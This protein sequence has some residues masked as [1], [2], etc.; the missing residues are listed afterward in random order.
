[1]DRPVRAVPSFGGSW[2]KINPPLS[3]WIMNVINKMGFTNMTPVQAATIPRAIKN[4]DCVVEAVTGSG[5]TLSFVVPVLERLSRNEESLQKDRIAAIVIAPTR[6]LATQIHSV[7]NQFLSSL[8]PSS[9]LEE[10]SQPFA[11]SSRAPSPESFDSLLPLPMLVTSGTSA[12]YE[13]FQTTHPSI[14]IGTPGRL[15]SILLSPRGMSV[16]GVSNF[17]I[18]VLDEADRLLS[19]PDHRRD[20]ERIMRHLPKQRRTHLFS[21]TMTDAVEELIG[22]GLRNPVRIVVNLKDKKK[23]GEERANERRIPMTLKNTYIVC[24]HAEKTLQLIR[25]LQAE[26]R[27]EAAKFIIFFSTCAAVDYFYRVLSR[28]PILSHFHLT[29]LHGDLPPNVR[30]NALSTFIV[31]PSSNLNPSVLL[32]TDIAARGVDFANIDV[33]IQYDA[34]T[35]PKTFSHRVGRTARAGRG[36]KA[37][38]LLGSGR[39]EDYVDF[40]A[41]RKIP[42]IKQPYLDENLEEVDMPTSIDPGAI[43]LMEDVRKILLTDRKLSDKGSKSY[44]SAFRAYSKHEASFIFRAGNLDHHSLAIAY[45]LLRLPAMPEIKDWRKRREEDKKRNEKLRE[46]GSMIEEGEEVAWEDANVDWDN[47]AYSSK[48]HETARLAT[49]VK[50]AASQ[51]SEDQKKEVRAKKKIK[52]EMREAWSEQRDKKVRKEERREKKDKKKQYEWELAQAE[53]GEFL[54]DLERIARARLRERKRGQDG[55]SHTEELEEYRNL[56]KEVKVERASKK[57]K[58]AAGCGFGGGMFDDLE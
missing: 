35:D 25:T 2:E 11:S 49:L 45:G 22:L 56:K 34:P 1:M 46:E 57:A 44:V 33:V 43:N 36:G 3:P 23:E 32:C 42:L 17:D 54:G 10:A 48:Q 4:Q 38:I 20:I 14:L 51:P 21:A 16:I 53:A 12:P 37:I 28:L 52:A 27:K 18:L 29:S 26:S 6:E 9:D 8:I 24:R 39:E 30:T 40:L 13:T 7:F 50:K 15:A 31:Y 55:H 19:S 58:K 47:F 5:K 41:I